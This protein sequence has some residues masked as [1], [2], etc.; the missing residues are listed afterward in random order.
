VVEGV[1][2]A[3]ASS[4]PIEVV[5]FAQ[6]GAAAGY[7]VARSPDQ[8]GDQVVRWEAFAGIGVQASDERPEYELI[9]G[10]QALIEIYGIHEIEFFA[11]EGLRLA[12]SEP[13]L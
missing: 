7:P 4:A 11:G 10:I 3:T 13:L 5:A 2:A 1:E 12:L 8:V 9:V 6:F